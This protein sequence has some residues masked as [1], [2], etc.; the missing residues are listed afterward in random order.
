MR[1]GWEQSISTRNMAV[2]QP[3]MIRIVLIISIKLH[4]LMDLRRFISIRRL[5]NQTTTL[6]LI[7]IL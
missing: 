6:N 5:E 4:F 3:D 2:E 7:H 1:A